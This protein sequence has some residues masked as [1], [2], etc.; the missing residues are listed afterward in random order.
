[1]DAVPKQITETR[2]QPT[3]EDRESAISRVNM[4]EIFG[5]KLKH[6]NKQICQCVVPSRPSPSSL[7]TS[8]DM[9]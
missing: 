4:G 7:S 6:H 9:Q 1:M 3:A 8:V 2:S 5:H